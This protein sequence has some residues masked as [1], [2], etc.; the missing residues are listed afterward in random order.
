MTAV[1]HMNMFWVDRYSPLLN[2]SDS[3]LAVNFFSQQGADALLRPPVTEVTEMYNEL[4]AKLA[5]GVDLGQIVSRVDDLAEK[6]KL[7]D[8]AIQRL[9]RASTTA[10]ASMKELEGRH[11]S[12]E[13]RVLDEH[14]ESRKRIEAFEKRAQE[15]TDMFIAIDARIN[16]TFGELNRRMDT[17]QEQTRSQ[18]QELN[19]RSLA[20]E[21]AELPDKKR[22][23]TRSR[24]N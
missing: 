22:Y 12:L 10:T 21:L 24:K 2:M 14:V 6:L 23:N 19:D 1:K 13:N 4:Q 11:Q 7:D 16:A 8:K 17:L 3:D 5:P 9:V 18:L 15:L 20:V